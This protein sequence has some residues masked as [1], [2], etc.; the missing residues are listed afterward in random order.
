MSSNRVSAIFDLA[1][2]A[3]LSISARLALLYTA[4]GYL[5]LVAST[6]FLY[7]ILMQ[8]MQRDDLHYVVDKVHMVEGTLLHYAEDSAFLDHEVKWE[9]GSYGI[10][11]RYI[12]YTRILD[13]NGGLVVETPDM[14]RLVPSST[15][16]PPVDSERTSA[17]EAVGRWHSPE[18]RSYYVLST[19]ARNVQNQQSW[20]VQ[21]ALD[22]TEEATL[23][24]NLRRGSIAVLLIGIVAS[25]CLGSLAARR[26]MRP[27][28]EIAAAAEQIT[29]NHLNERIDAARW[30]E[31]LNGLALALNRMFGRLENS[32]ARISQ[33]TA[34]LAH[35]LR[36]PIHSLMGEA[37]VAL[38]V[39]R[40]P[41]E[42]RSVLESSLEEFGRLSRMINEML[43]LARAE[44]PQSQIERIQVDARREI[45]AVKEF[46]DA[47]TEAHGVTVTCQGQ[48]EIDADPLLFRRA[49][50]NLLSNALRCTPRGGRIDMS[51]AQHDDGGI[52]LTVSDSGCGMRPED[53]PRVCDRLYCADRVPA[54]R[55]KGT[56]LGLAI[57]KS[58]VDLH[59][60]SIAVDSALGRGTTMTLRFPPATPAAA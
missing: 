28:R 11:Q 26:G 5:M 47:L 27:L 36:T 53:V 13:E 54:E 15:F 19:W 4:S 10:E 17:L 6:A 34:D 1:P 38:S 32:F 46:F 57:V 8:G 45:E 29:A 39:D 16:A 42:Y 35:E 24:T 51:V 2:R 33:C 18:G 41:E 25:A 23:L 12:F 55:P 44:N 9:G 7:W 3:P 14:A 48:G 60:G 56:G 22:D 59:G 37:E 30:P 49:V 43:F 40:K 31:E 21:V 58:I 20:V 50:I 52:V